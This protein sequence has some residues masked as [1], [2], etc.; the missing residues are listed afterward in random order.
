MFSYI[1]NYFFNYS[2]FTIID[3]TSPDAHL[4]NLE[5]NITPNYISK[6]DTIQIN[7]NGNLDKTITDGNAYLEIY[8]NNN[9]ILSKNYDINDKVPCPINEGFVNLTFTEKMPSFIIPGKYIAKL[10]V[11]DQDNEQV[12]C[13][14]LHINL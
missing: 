8:K 3:C 4:K 13:I 7:A 12:F 14:E 2:N 11:T 1:L 6:G 5:L 9:R 10:N